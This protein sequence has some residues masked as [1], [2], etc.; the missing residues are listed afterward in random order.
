MGRV[1]L[2]SGGALGKE[3]PGEQAIS[4]SHACPGHLPL[5]CRGTH[6]AGLQQGSDFG[7]P[8]ASEADECGNVSPR[9]SG[10]TPHRSVGLA[11]PGGK[12]GFPAE[13][14]NG[15]GFQEGLGVG[16][17]WGRGR[18][19]PGK[20]FGVFR[21]CFHVVGGGR[22]PITSHRSFDSWNNGGYASVPKKEGGHHSV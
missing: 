15:L 2:W 17:V 22:D 4:S 5:R 21:V 6:R 20:G 19:I 14:T 8:E 16:W 1:V 3:V 13:V 18:A 12:E 9:C 7:C 10:G 11:A